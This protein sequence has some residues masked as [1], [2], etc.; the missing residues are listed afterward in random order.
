[1]VLRHFG[2]KD[3][4]GVRLPSIRVYRSTVQVISSGALNAYSFDTVSW[5]YDCN[6][7]L[8]DPTKLYV[9]KTGIYIATG[10][11][12]VDANSTGERSINVRDSGAILRG[13]VSQPTPSASN[14]TRLGL[15]GV[16]VYLKTGQWVEMVFFQNSGGNLNGNRNVD[17]TGWFSLYAQELF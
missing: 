8:Q 15:P 4:K 12:D 16:P 10:V 6:W 14:N 2:Q 3:A 7:N 9:R 1:M 5:N 17:Y 13:G 11:I